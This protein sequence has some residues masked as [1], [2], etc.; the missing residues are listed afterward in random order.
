MPATGPV[1]EVGD[2]PAADAPGRAAA[3]VTLE[4]APDPSA[5]GT[6]REWVAAALDGWPTPSVETARLL[7]SELVTNAVLHARTEIALRRR[8]EG[9]RARFEVSDGRREGPVPKRYS[10]DSATGRGLRLVDALATEWGVTR[11]GRG[12]TV[13]FVVTPDAGGGSAQAGR[14]GDADVQAQAEP[15]TPAEA[16]SPPNATSPAA[17]APCEVATVQVLAIPLDVYLEAEQHDDAVMRELTLLLQ[18]SS[19]R[20]DL[21][22]PARLLEI[23]ADVRAAFGP[24]ITSV[25]VQVERALRRRRAT[26]DLTLRAPVEGWEALRRLA[27]Q[28]DEV[29]RFCEAGNLLTL[30]SSRRLRH[31]RKW[32]AQQVADQLR[33]MSPT[34]WSEGT[35]TSQV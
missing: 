1:D 6:A 9:A 31:F 10:P 34:P 14:Q 7:V 17:T 15:P 22:V 23:A 20:G 5:A 30:G 12:K 18:S 2:P 32:F 21:E 4:L 29:D 33:G 28:F 19:A 13:W 25:R 3:S 11:A 26:V 24:V 27:S 16:A 35:E 8:L